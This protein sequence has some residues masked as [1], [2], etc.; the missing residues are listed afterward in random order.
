MSNVGDYK[1]SGLGFYSL[2]MCCVDNEMGR[3]WKGKTKTFKTGKGKTRKL[4]KK[5]ESVTKTM[6]VKLEGKREKY[7]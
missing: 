1:V 5:E 4:N 2:R 6:V 7:G 3:E